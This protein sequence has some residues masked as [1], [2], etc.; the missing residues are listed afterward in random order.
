MDCGNG[1]LLQIRRRIDPLGAGQLLEILST[2]PS[3]AEDLPA[4]CRMTGNE[5]VSTWHDPDAKRWSFLV[6][7]GRFVPPVAGAAK[8]RA[9]RRWARR[10]RDEAVAES[11]D[12]TGARTGGIDRDR[13]ALGLR[14]RELAPARLAAAG[15]ARAARRPP[16]RV[17][18]PGAG[19][20]R[21]GRGRPGPGRGRR[22]RRHRRRAAAGQLRQLRR[23]PAREL[24][25]HP[26]RRPAPLRRA[27]R[28]SSRAS[29]GPSTS[30]PSR[31]ATRPSSG[32]SPAT[33]PARWPCTSSRRSGA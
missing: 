10:S 30:P 33:P 19:R 26:D 5:L 23:R 18:V 31:C 27:S 17:A 22:G 20:P 6:S 24:P 25:A 3:V 4:W 14:H 13:A 1:L 7:K 21:R 8:R 2:E 29:C 12:R 28:R 32:G 15:P 9:G 11:S 16:G